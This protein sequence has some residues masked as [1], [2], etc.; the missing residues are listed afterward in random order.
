MSDT[1]ETD[2]REQQLI[3]DGSNIGDAFFLLADHARRLERERDEAREELKEEELSFD[4]LYD[5]SIDYLREIDELKQKLKEVM[6]CYDLLKE[7]ISLKECIKHLEFA[8]G[9]K[10]A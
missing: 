5:Q 3:H 8:N 6:D 1:P 7:N 4:H 10:T 9:N 2:A